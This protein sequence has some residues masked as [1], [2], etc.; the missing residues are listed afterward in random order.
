M[1]IK[2][3]I[4]KAYGN[5]PKEATPTLEIFTELNKPKLIPK[6]LRALFK[7]KNEKNSNY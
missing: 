1:K 5:I 6:W 4:D 2:E 7:K 3:T